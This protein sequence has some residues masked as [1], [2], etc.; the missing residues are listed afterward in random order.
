M[1]G[2]GRKGERNPATLS[3]ER[4]LLIQ[5][6]MDDWLEGAGREVDEP[7]EPPED[8][9]PVVERPV[10]H[11]AA[12]APE[13]PAE[14]D[15]HAEPELR[16]AAVEPETNGTVAEAPRRRRGRPRGAHKRRQVHFHVDSD[17]DQMLLRAAGRFGSQQK[18]LIAALHALNE[19]LA[20]RDQV[21]LLQEECSRQRRLL[22]EAQAL[23]KSG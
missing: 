4:K 12:A 17:Q 13:A 15:T 10:L 5:R 19:V 9:P 23:F 7:E 6:Y 1:S 3:D 8:E 22:A 11:L 21:E 16:L 20:L 14:P 18:A 2:L